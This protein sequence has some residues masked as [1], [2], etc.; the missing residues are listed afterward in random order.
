MHRSHDSKTYQSEP[1]RSPQ[2]GRA[3]YLLS[4]DI[5]GLIALAVIHAL[6]PPRASHAALAFQILISLEDSKTVLQTQAKNQSR[7]SKL[8]VADFSQP[9]TPVQ[10]SSSSSSNT[11][12]C[13]PPSQIV[14]WNSAAPIPWPKAR[15]LRLFSRILGHRRTKARRSRAATPFQVSTETRR[16][17]CGR[18]IQSRP[19]Q[20]SQHWRSASGELR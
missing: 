11:T 18:A 1:R 9:P 2:R 3:L 7:R 20:E 8:P 16:N 15:G 19:K 17:Q 10:H 13:T 5:M 12:S 4:T 14:D 6:A